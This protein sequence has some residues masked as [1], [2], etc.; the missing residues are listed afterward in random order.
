METSTINLLLMGCTFLPLLSGV[1][2]GLFVGT[3]KL[4]HRICIGALGLA[5]CC[6]I[7]LCYLYALQSQNVLSVPLYRWITVA[8]FSVIIGLQIDGLVCAMVSMITSISLLIH[9]YSIAYMCDD[10]G[11]VRFFSLL[12]LFTFSMLFLVASNNVIGLFFGWEGVSLFSYFLIGFYYY[13]DSAARASIKAFLIN[14]FGDCAFCLGLIL[15]IYHTGSF[16]YQTI[17]SRMDNLVAVKLVLLGQPISAVMLTGLLLSIGAMTKSAQMPL[18][19]WL[20]D[21]MEGPTPVSALLHAATMVTAG[22][23][24]LSRFFLVIV[25]SLYLQNILAFVGAS[26]ALFLGLLALSEM[27]IKRIIAYST[28]SQLG[29]MMLAVGVGGYQLAIFHLIIH[30]YFKACLFMAAGSVI[31]ALN[32]E[33]N[34][35]RM[36][37]LW[38]SMP[39]TT[40]CFLLSALSLSGIP[41]LAGFNSKDLILAAVYQQHHYLFA[42]EY[43]YYAALAGFLIT[44]L[45]IFRLFWIVFLGPRNYGHI[46]VYESPPVIILP[47]IVL[48]IMSVFGSMLLQPILVGHSGLNFATTN[49]YVIRLVSYIQ[50]LIETGIYTHAIDGPGVYVSMLGVLIGW[51]L[52]FRNTELL[53]YAFPYFYIFNWVLEHKYGLD[54]VNDR[55]LVPLILWFARM[56]ALIGEQFLIDRT[57][58]NRIS[59]SMRVVSEKF[60]RKQ[61]SLLTRYFLI[62]VLSLGILLGTA[63]LRFD[64][65]LRGL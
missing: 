62:M 7:G 61:T 31:L 23:Y 40:I 60:S 50:Y 11:Y 4:A 56:F 48:A 55:V 6:A 44:P 19:I 28:L 47:M 14:R 53:T 34:I 13:K 57:V 3:S 37:G 10:Q 18:H 22:I 32:H 26:G 33:Q 59:R 27:D 24:L 36:G 20:P 65:L 16:D 64:F 30:A 42:G 15:L 63:S 39:L 25:Q 49:E 29:Y 1:F 38:R 2:V 9:I 52:F 41:P 17:F 12:S 58:E 54:W 45:Y 35:S 8:D 51:V 21:S 46:D 43:I 5:F